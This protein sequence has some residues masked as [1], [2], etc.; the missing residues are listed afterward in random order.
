MTLDP[1]AVNGVLRLPGVF[2]AEEAAAMRAEV[3]R[4]LERMAMVEIVGALRPPPEAG[5]ALWEVGRASAFA[6]LPATVSAAID[7]VVGPHVWE[8]VAEEGGG[9]AAPNLPLPGGVEWTV[10]HAAWHVDEPTSAVREHGWGLLAFVMLDAVEAGGGA[11]VAIAGSQRRLRALAATA[12]PEGLL[13]TEAAMD[14]LRREEPW[15]EELFTPGGDPLARVRRF[16]NTE[17]LSAGIPLRV[18]ELTGGAGDVVLMDPRCLH[19]VSANT[20][21]PRLQMRLTCRRAV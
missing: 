12:A 6:G 14:A 19:T 3:E 4:V 2:G 8:P 20:R 10:P 7:A 1:L 9:L 5:D 15:F 16:M 21:R 17:Y 18:I 11:T 13:T